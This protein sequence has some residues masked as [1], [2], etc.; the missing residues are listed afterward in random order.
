M[1]GLPGH[2]QASGNAGRVDAVILPV[3]G[4]YVLWGHEHRGL[5]MDTQ[6]GVYSSGRCLLFHSTKSTAIIRATPRATTPSS[7]QGRCVETWKRYLSIFLRKANSYHG[8]HTNNKG[9]N[10]IS[11]LGAKDPII[12]QPLTDTMDSLIQQPTIYCWP[13]LVCQILGQCFI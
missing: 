8:M 11:R 4:C 1:A 6:I 5:L 10:N 12:S 9:I 3:T 2:W 13:S 7:D